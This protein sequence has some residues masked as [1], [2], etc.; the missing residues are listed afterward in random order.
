MTE[1]FEAHTPA[2]HCDGCA[3][4]IK[5]SLSRLSGV[6]DVAV[7]VENKNVTAH[8]EADTTSAQAIHDRLTQ[9]GFPPQSGA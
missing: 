1:V 2:I 9:A 7:D 4:S 3:Q 8:Y 6:Q 5:R